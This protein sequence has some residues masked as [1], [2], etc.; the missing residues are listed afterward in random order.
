MSDQPLTPDEL[1]RLRDGQELSPPCDG[2]ATKP[3][4]ESDGLEH[5]YHAEDCPVIEQ[6]QRIADDHDPTQP[7]LICDCCRED[8]QGDGHY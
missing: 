7:I 4:L 1:E 3:V 8:P 6:I 2:C 5:F